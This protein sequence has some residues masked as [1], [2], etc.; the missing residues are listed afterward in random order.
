MPTP[1]PQDMSA[2]TGEGEDELLSRVMRL[3]LGRGVE[4][5]LRNYPDD[6]VEFLLE[7]ARDLISKGQCERAMAVYEAVIAAPPSEADAQDA[8]VERI[9][10]LLEQGDTAAADEAIGELSKRGPMEMP[11]V[12]LAE[13]LEARERLEDA[14][15]WFNSACRRG[16]RQVPEDAVRNLLDLGALR[17]RARVRS[18]LG[19]AED[20]FDVA[21]WTQYGESRMGGRERLVESAAG[22]EALPQGTISACFT[23]S[24]FDRARREG[25]LYGEEAERAGDDPDAYYLAAERA[26]RRLAEEHPDVKVYFAV[27]SVEDLVAYAAENGRDHA[28]P[29]TRNAFVETL[30]EDDPRIIAWPPRRNEACWCG[31]GRKYKKCCGSPSKR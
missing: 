23:R 26:V 4:Y 19:L 2:V 14:L 17:G 22:Q 7:T 21:V 28:A 3:S 16:L 9:D 30:R 5:V 27:H 20:E 15:T 24:S 1:D 11:A 13:S 6:T 31:A 29:E 25:L 10:L 18:A 12:L 8:M